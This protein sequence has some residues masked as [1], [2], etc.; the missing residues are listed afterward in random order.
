M[1]NG[2][3]KNGRRKAWLFQQQKGVCYL[4]STRACKERGGQMR[5]D[6]KH[7]CDWASIEH[8]VPKSEKA[9]GEVHLILLACCDCNNAKGSGAPDARWI[10][11]AMRLHEGW[12]E[13][14]RSANIERK[15]LPTTQDER[16]IERRRLARK[17]KKLKKRVKRLNKKIC[18][19]SLED[20]RRLRHRID[21]E[22]E[23]RDS[24]LGELQRAR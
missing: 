9:H 3:P 14:A 4:M 23:A 15:A 20:E 24:A 8:V 17:R 1:S 21:Q 6:G 10:A 11:L 13:H 2:G 5:L 12:I 19:W 22:K 18:G 16:T 7:R